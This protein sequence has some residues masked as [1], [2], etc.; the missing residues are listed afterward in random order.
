M[1]LVRLADWEIRLTQ[2]FERSR[3]S[4]FQWGTFDCAIHAANCINAITGTDLAASLRGTYATEAQANQVLATY[5]GTIEGL[6]VHFAGD[7]AMDQAAPQFARRG[8]MVLVH[9]GDPGRAL[10]IVDLTGR[11]AL[12]AAVAGIARMPMRRW[13]RAWRVG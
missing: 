11:F 12:C 1:S 3:R 6:A 2:E 13:L 9:N 5:G 4:I 10:G 7:S 8:D